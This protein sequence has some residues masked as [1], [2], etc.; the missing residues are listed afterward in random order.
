MTEQPGLF[1]LD[2]GQPTGNQKRRRHEPPQ[3]PS[4]R[5]DADTAAI[6]ELISGD[7]LHAEDRTAVVRAILAA[8]AAN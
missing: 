7:P 3:F 2:G 6:L 1:S 4:G 8:A 5:V